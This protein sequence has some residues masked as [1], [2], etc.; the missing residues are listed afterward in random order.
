MVTQ[1]KQVSR[2][3]KITAIIFITLFILETIAVTCLIGTGLNETIKKDECRVNVCRGYDSFYYDY[4]GGCFC[5]QEN[6][7]VK[8][9][10]IR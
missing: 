3:W 7:I 4:M 2:G 6:E 5:Y 1:N 9:E 8:Q 10:I